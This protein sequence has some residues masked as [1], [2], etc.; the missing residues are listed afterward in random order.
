MSAYVERLYIETL[1]N[2]LQF[3]RDLL[4]LSVPLQIEAGLVGVK[5]YAIALEHGRHGKILEQNVIWR[6]NISS[7]DEAPNEILRPFFHL[8]WAK[9]G[10]QRPVDFDQVVEKIFGMDPS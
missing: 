3:A 2:Y 9:C 7:Y 8:F 10:V 5:G 1:A 6:S 4:N